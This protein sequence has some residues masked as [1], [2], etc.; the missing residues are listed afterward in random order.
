MSI[1]LKFSIMIVSIV[2]SLDTLGE[3]M[4]SKVT[5]K[6]NG[7]LSLNGQISVPSNKTKKYPAVLVL[8]GSGQSPLKERPVNDSFIQLITKTGENEIIGFHYNKRGSGE[9]SEN[10]KYLASGFYTHVDDA[11]AALNYL[12]K[13]PYVDEDQIYLMGQSIGGMLAT[14]VALREKVAGLILYTSPARPLTVFMPEQN[15]LISKYMGKTQDEIDK[16]VNGLERDLF[17]ME[18]GNYVCEA[19]NCGLIDGEEV[20]EEAES[21]KLLVEVAQSNQISNLEKVRLPTLLIHGT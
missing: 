16:Y 12:K 7:S 10:G 21:V 19:P 8:E 14:Q 5:F 17:K 15:R 1:G 11:L 18:S 2:F 6:V 9:N 20:Y 13:I 3:G 4:N